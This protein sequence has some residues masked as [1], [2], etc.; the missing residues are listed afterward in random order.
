MGFEIG[1]TA[2]SGESEKKSPEKSPTFY[3]VLQSLSPFFAIVL[4]FNTWQDNPSLITAALDF[5]LRMIAHI[6]ESTPSL[7]GQATVTALQGIGFHYW[8]LYFE[9]GILCHAILSITKTF[10][11]GVSTRLKS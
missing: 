6:C 3:G 9:G 1:T 8:M 10:F 11:V 7:G 2:V 5:N 4:L